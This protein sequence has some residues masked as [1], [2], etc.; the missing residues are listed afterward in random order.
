MA[1]QLLAAFF[2]SPL[3]YLAVALGAILLVKWLFR[4][5]VN[6]PPFPV[7]PYPI[8]GHLPFL[9]KTPRETVAEWTNKSGE[10]FSLYM[11]QTLV[12][13][14]N[15]YDILKETLVKQSEHFTDRPP[16]F[17]GSIS[18]EGDKGIINNSGHEWKEQRST[19]ISILRNFGMGKKSLA[20]NIQGEIS[21][22][23]N[24]L[25]SYKGK[26]TEVRTLTNSSVSN[27]ICA[28]IVGQRFE[29]SDPYFINF[30]NIFSEQMKL[31]AGTT[32]LNWF[33]WLRFVPGDLFKAKKIQTNHRAL[34]N[35]FSDRYITQSSHNFDENNVD[36]FITAYLIES[37][38]RQNAGEATTLN[39]VNLRRVVANL[40]IAGSETTSTTMMWFMIFMIHYPDIQKKVYKEIEEVVGTEREPSINDK[41]HLNYLGATIMETQRLASIVP[42]G[43][44]HM[45]TTDVTINGYTIPKGARIWPNLD[46][47]LSDKKT[48]GDPTVFRP[49][50]F[51]DA[52]RNLIV[53]EHF[54]PFSLGRRICPGESLAKMEL[55]LFLS[56]L[57]QKF[58]LLP[59][60]PTN[61]PPLKGLFGVT[62]PPLPFELRF[63]E[64]RTL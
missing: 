29:Y 30:M 13:V 4:K 26:P 49:E 63:I 11:G 22:Y 27:V 45:C 39:D 57:V 62:C 12:V 61:L 43:L 60:D 14:L 42:F 35:Y 36:N 28:I 33:H 5:Q 34:I 46:A 17:I 52:Q 9:K 51:L 50:R 1:A 58:E 41:T 21:A 19:T 31:L 16:S 44:T 8:L 40:F 7:K 54:V 64:R 53:P 47:V 6:I 3:S 37:K 24:E 2:S 25:S 55:F 48:W 18:L 38:K 32:I 56:A 59:T 23:L 20:D 10:M 15:T